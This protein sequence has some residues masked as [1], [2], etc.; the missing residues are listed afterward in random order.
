MEN[1]QPLIDALAEHERTQPE[2]DRLRD[3]A[4]TGE[5]IAHWEAAKL[6]ALKPVQEAFYQVTSSINSREKCNLIS[7]EDACRLVN[8][9]PENE[10]HWQPTIEQRVGKNW[11]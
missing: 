9:P 6:A 10:K 11:P 7:I 4:Q 3:S 5:D 8:G 2:R 1:K